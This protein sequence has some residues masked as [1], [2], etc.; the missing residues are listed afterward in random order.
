MLTALSIERYI[1]IIVD[2]K[3]SA[4]FQRT[5]VAVIS[6]IA[7]WTVSLI[8]CAPVFYGNYSDA[9]SAY[10]DPQYRVAVI[11]SFVFSYIAPLVIITIIY[12]LI[13]RK[14]RKRGSSIKVK[15]RDASSSKDSTT[16]SKAE[17]DHDYELKILKTVC[18]IV[19]IFTFNFGCLYITSIV[20]MIL[21]LDKLTEEIVVQVSETIAIMT[22]SIHPIVYGMTHPSF[23]PHV[24]RLILCREEC[25]LR[26]RRGEC[27]CSRCCRG[28]RPTSLRSVM[29]KQSTL[30]GTVNAN[31]EFVLVER[32]EAEQSSQRQ[33]NI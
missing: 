29:R 10:S 30:D 5:R 4:K 2:P 23:N 17:D 22:A 1:K 19:I 33:E 26:C 28:G 20:L 24:R 21:P 6:C 14:L 27:D 15:N 31:D 32:F 7:V 3:K 11:I 12:F 18:F 13:R 8:I 25:C 9:A 16:A